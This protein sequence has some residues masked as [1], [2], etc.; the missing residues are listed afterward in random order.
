MNLIRILG[1]SILL[2]SN[3]ILSDSLNT[4][5]SIA[6]ID[7]RGQGVEQG[8]A[9]NFSNKFRKLLLDGKRFAVMERDNM[10]SILEEQGYQQSG[11]MSTECVVDV[12]K[13]IGV[14]YV[15]AGA[16]GKVGQ[17]YIINARLV[18]VETGKIEKEA[19]RADKISLEDLYLSFVNK[20]YCDIFDKS[21][22][23]ID[24]SRI[25]FSI[26][27]QSNE[28]M[29]KDSLNTSE[30]LEIIKGQTVLSVYGETQYY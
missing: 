18:N 30:I 13:L 1:I 16:V 22:K 12:G 19:E 5:K 7:F 25:L 21:D 10:N 24:K 20:L 3:S 29:R 6:L 14:H 4:I 9:N 8:V 26:K 23:A 2:W 11:C 15:I 28:K 17:L 27:T